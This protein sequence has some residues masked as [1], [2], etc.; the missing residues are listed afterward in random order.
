LDYQ[1]VFRRRYDGKYNSIL[2]SVCDTPKKYI[3][4]PIT[5]LRRHSDFIRI[6]EFNHFYMNE[7]KTEPN[8]PLQTDTCLSRVVLRTPRAKHVS[9]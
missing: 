2:S 3:Q 8:Q 9:V 6:Y 5:I 7:K 1:L 4:D